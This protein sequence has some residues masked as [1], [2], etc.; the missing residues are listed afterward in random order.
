MVAIA[1]LKTVLSN[2]ED[3]KQ[4]QLAAIMKE[5]SLVSQQSTVISN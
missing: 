5:L 3:V 4:Q 1:Y 2:S